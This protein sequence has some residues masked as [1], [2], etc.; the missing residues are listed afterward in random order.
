MSETI[1]TSVTYSTYAEFV[2]NTRVP[3]QV[4]IN[5]TTVWTPAALHAEYIL[6]S[7]VNC[8]RKYDPDQ[9]RLFPTIDRYGDSLIPADVRKAHIELTSWLLLK[10]APTAS[11][12]EVT[13]KKVGGESWQSTGYSRNYTRGDRESADK[14]NMNL[15]PIVLRLLAPWHTKTA[16]VNY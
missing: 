9:Y 8:V 3:A 14:T 12:E 16:A 1:P 13:G 7:Y 4:S 10:G 11:D 2:A 15:P 5:Q 6:D